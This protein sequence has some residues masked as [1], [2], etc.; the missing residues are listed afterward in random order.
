VEDPYAGIVWSKL[1]YP[2]GRL[3]EAGGIIWQDASGWNYG[4]SDDPAKPEYNYLREVD[5]CS[6]A[7]LMIPKSLFQSVGGFDAR[8]AP[9]YYEDA[10]LAFKVRQA[11]FR[12]FHILN[13]LRQ[14]GHRV[15]FVPD[16]LA[17][18]L[19]YGQ[20]L[21]RRGIEIIYQPYFKKVRD[22]LVSRGQEFDAVVL[23]RCD[24]AR[25]HIADTRLYA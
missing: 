17:N 5:Y 1:I 13:I 19:P 9:A 18:I 22:F 23:S 15:T 6:A 12:I 7:A 21:Q 16:N 10:D 3:Q 8:Y 4:R 11:G 24:F 2:D 14:L 20:E 25:K